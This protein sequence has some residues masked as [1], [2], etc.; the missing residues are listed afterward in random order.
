MRKG[1][2]GVYRAF[3]PLGG[4]L[5]AFLAA[6]IYKIHGGKPF[7][8]CVVCMGPRRGIEPQQANLG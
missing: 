1:W 6:N 4:L 2:G 5:A 7:C 3:E 8:M